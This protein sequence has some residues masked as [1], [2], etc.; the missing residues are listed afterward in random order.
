MVE[1]Q[2]SKLVAWV[3]FPSLAPKCAH[4]SVDRVPGYEPVGRRF[5]SSWAR[6]HKDRSSTCPYILFSE[7]KI[8]KKI[9]PDYYFDKFSDA[10][11]EFLYSLGIKGLILDI[12]NTLEPYENPLPTEGVKAWLNAL[13]GLGIKPCF[14]SNN[15][16]ERVE[17]FNSELG[18]PAYSK[19][20]K[21]FKRNILAAMEIIGSDKT[22]TVVMGDQIFTDVLAAKNAGLMAILVKPIKDKTDLFTKFKRLLEKPIIKKYEKRNNK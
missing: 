9:M 12:D 4:S 8:V 5:E 14:V 7:V 3:R 19:A 1:F 15:N 10:A 18:L 22:N 21:P 17:L 6:Q 11:P 20:K 13:I 16:K 2:P